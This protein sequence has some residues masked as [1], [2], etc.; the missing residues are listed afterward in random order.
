[1]KF[2]LEQKR[3]LEYEIASLRM[4]NEPIS[5]VV[6][7]TGN[8]NTNRV[9]RCVYHNSNGHLTE[10]CRNYLGMQIQERINLIKEKQACWPCLKIGHKSKECRY[11]KKSEVDNCD[12]YHHHSLHAVNANVATLHTKILNENEKDDIWSSTC[13]LQIMKIPSVDRELSVL[14]DSGDSI[15]LVTFKAANQLRLKGKAVNLSIFKVGGQ[16]ENLS[17]LKYM[18]PLTDVYRNIF[19]IYV[20]GIDKISSSVQAIDNNII[21]QE[22]PELKCEGIQVV[23]GEVNVLVGFNYAALH[24]VKVKCIHK[25]LL[26]MKNRFGRC[27]AGSC[28][29]FQGNDKILVHDAIVN[30]AVVKENDFLN[31]E[32]M[33]VR[34][35]PIC[36]GCKCGKCSLGSS[37]C[38]IKEQKE[39]NLIEKGLEIKGNCWFA[40]YPWIRDPKGLPDNKRI[41]LKILESTERRLLNNAEY[42]KMYCN[43][44]K[45]MVDRKVADKLTEDE[46]TEYEGPY[47]YLTHHEVLKSE[48]STPFR[49]VF[50]S[51]LNYQGQN[52]NDYWAKG[53]NLLNNLIG[54]LLRFRERK[55]AM[56]GDIKKMYYAIKISSVDQHTHRFLWRDCDIN[57]KP[58]TY[59]MKSISFGDKPAGNIAIT[60]LNKTAELSRSK[61]PEAV[62]IIKGNTYMDDII[63]SFDDLSHANEIASQIDIIIKKGIVKRW[64]TS[65]KDSSTNKERL[66]DFS[67]VSREHVLGLVWDRAKDVLRYNIRLNFSPKKR[68]IFTGPYVER[69]DILQS[70]PQKIRKR[71]SLS[72]INSIYDPLGL[73]TPFTIKAK[74]ILKGLWKVGFGWDEDIGGPEREKLIQFL[75]SMFKL[76]DVDFNRCLKPGNAI[77]NTVLVT[78]SD[79]SNGAFGACSYLHWETKGGLF[80][81]VLVASKSRVSPMKILSIVRLELCAAVIGIRLANL[82]KEEIRFEICQEIYIVDSQ[83]VRSMIQKDSD[84]FKTFAA[85]RIGEIQET[86]NSKDWYWLDSSNNIADWITRGKNPEEFN[87]NSIW[88]TG[89]DFMRT[90]TNLWQMQQSVCGSVLPEES[91]VVDVSLIQQNN[92]VANKT[93]TPTPSIRS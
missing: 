36:G 61:Y 14:W 84:G 37:Y 89:P 72:K 29:S 5:Q 49:I 28:N 74:I 90:H 51:S 43:Q 9:N 33:R 54:I 81:A 41:A 34:C 77:G 17:S 73:I 46:L 15:S 27:L 6:Y 78:F 66:K 19:K 4:D 11:K 40:T 59:I 8:V 56:I 70:I 45:D 76:E 52:L 3:I 42:A 38:T 16:V 86:T 53:P 18:L 1:M 67:E 82:I 57:S 12:R 47:Y 85:V 21:F 7:Y 20:Y 75:V 91:K 13:L 68:G 62:D 39:Q 83:V 24:P 80:K 35:K 31:I 32:S 93:D 88:Q 44:I 30:H 58:D 2:L 23:S 48:S 26:L 69:N 64:I 25:N 87:E 22:C 65:A 10:E 60:A 79:A 92:N 55:V 50:N 63:G 71:I